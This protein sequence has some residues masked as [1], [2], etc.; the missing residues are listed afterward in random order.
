[1]NSRAP[2]RPLPADGRFLQSIGPTPLVPVRLNEEGPTIWCKL[3]FLNPSG[4]TKDRIARYMLEKAWRLGELCPGG[5]VVEASS[6][7]TS[8]AL[9][10]AS[11][12]MGAEVHRGDARGRHGRARAHHPRLR[13]RR[14]AG[15]S[16]ARASAAPSR[17]GGAGQGARGLRA[18]PVREPGQRRGAPGVD[19][20]GDPLA[21]AGRAGARRGE[22]RGH[23]RH[24]GGAVP[25]LRGGGLPGDAV[26]GQ[27]HLRHG[28]RHRVLQLQLARARRGG[29]AVH[30]VPRG[31][32]AGAAWS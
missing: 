16:R 17:G 4:S 5:E 18:A 11:A 7:S 8:I 14:G 31:G 1:M 19:G 20:A 27:A 24:G 15:A 23:G 6:G 26:R 32:P 9:A 29:R 21:G 3:E 30:A 22:R 25:G 2:C 13:R 28:Q 12:Q 10:L